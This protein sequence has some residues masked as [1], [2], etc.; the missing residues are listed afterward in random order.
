MSQR[1][2]GCDFFFSN[3]RFFFFFKGRCP[4]H[5]RSRRNVE[6]VQ[7]EVSEGQLDPPIVSNQNPWEAL[8]GPWED[9]APAG[10]L[11]HQAPRQGLG[12]S[13]LCLLAGPRGA[14]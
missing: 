2:E 12:F 6:N 3:T 1:K 7:L 8:R 5:A 14:M 9:T 13:N 4:S 10:G 11:G